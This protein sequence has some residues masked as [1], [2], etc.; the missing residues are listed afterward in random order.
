MSKLTIFYFSGKKNSKYLNFR[1]EIGQKV[2][3]S[4]FYLG[5]FRSKSRFLA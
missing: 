3:I 5:I 2:V 4:W 1:A